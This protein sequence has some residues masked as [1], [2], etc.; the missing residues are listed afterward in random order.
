MIRIYLSLYLGIL[1]HLKVLF[2]EFQDLSFSSNW[3]Y[4]SLSR[5]TAAPDFEIITLDSDH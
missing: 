3:D 5:F 4:L 2:H 1:A